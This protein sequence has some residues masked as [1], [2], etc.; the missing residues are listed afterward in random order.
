MKKIYVRLL[1]KNIMHEN[2]RHLRGIYFKTS[3]EINKI[4]TLR[5]PPLQTTLKKNLS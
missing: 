4:Y 3:T 2:F 1:V 5:L